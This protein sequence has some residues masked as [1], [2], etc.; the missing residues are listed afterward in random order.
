M[1]KKKNISIGQSAAIGAG[2]G[3]LA[4]EG[5]KSLIKKILK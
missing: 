5:I 2:F 4:T 3:L 1:G